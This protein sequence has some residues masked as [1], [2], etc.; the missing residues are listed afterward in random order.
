LASDGKFKEDALNS[1][2]FGR[3]G[4]TALQIMDRAGWK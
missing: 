3:N 2:V 4:A 1:A